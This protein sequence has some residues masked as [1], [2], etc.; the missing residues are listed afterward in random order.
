MWGL[1][2]LGFVRDSEQSGL[3]PGFQ[4]EALAIDIND[5]GVVKD[6]NE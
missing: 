3:T 1:V 4:S 5:D 2:L 6:P